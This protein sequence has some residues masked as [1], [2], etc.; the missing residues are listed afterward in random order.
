MTRNCV[1]Y[2]GLVVG[3]LLDYRMR[4]EVVCWICRKDEKEKYMLNFEIF[5]V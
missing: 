2:A 3:L 5:L 4:M 1:I